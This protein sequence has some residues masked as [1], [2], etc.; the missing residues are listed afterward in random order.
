MCWFLNLGCK[1]LS[2][3]PPPAPAFVG[4]AGTPIEYLTL[5]AGEFADLVKAHVFYNKPNEFEMQRVLCRIEDALLWM[6]KHLQFDGFGVGSIP[7]LR[8]KNIA[9]LKA[10]YPG[11]YSEHAALNRDKAAEYAAIENG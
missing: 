9:K 8:A 4:A 6:V 5:K 10:R 1:A 3:L 11:K 7:E 2:H